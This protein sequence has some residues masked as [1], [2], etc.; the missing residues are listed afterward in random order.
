MNVGIVAC[1]KGRTGGVFEA[2]YISEIMLEVQFS[3][4]TAFR[5]AKT[6]LRDYF[7]YF[8]EEILEKV[9]KQILKQYLII[10]SATSHISLVTNLQSFTVQAISIR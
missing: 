2:T 1:V 7:T 8:Q 9:N 5:P 4:H 10:S 3:S 6:A